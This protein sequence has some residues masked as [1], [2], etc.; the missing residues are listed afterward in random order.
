MTATRHNIRSTAPDVR[1]K[2]MRDA[3]KAAGDGYA[4]VRYDSGVGGAETQHAIIVGVTEPLPA[5]RQAAQL[6]IKFGTAPTERLWTIPGTFLHW[7]E[8]PS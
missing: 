4:I 7:I 3:A 1:L 2:R 8:V 5:V 6:L